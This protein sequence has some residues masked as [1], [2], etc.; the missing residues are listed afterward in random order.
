MKKFKTNIGDKEISFEIKNW[1][2]KANGEVL[3]TCGKT[4]VLVTAVMEEEDTDLGYFPLMVNY[5]ERF[6]ARGEILGSRYLRREGKPSNNAVLIA[7]LIDRTVRP[8]FPKGMKKEVQI[9]ATCL[10]WDGENDPDILGILGASFA[11][12]VS[13]IPWNGPIGAVRAVLK[14]GQVVINPVYEQR[15]EARLEI[16]LCGVKNSRE[17][18]VINM[19]EMEGEDA[20]EEQI[21]K[22]AQTALP[23]LQKICDLLEKA[24]K[25]AGREKIKLDIKKDENLAQQIDKFLQNKLEKTLFQNSNPNQE[26]LD[27]LKEVKKQTLEHIKG[28]YDQ[29]EAKQK[30]KQAGDIFE[31]KLGALI[32][33]KGMQGERV[34]G[35]KPNQVREIKCQAGPIP[36]THGSGL[37]SRGTTTSLSVITLGGPHEEKLIEGMEVSTKKRFLHH[38]N[39]PP[40]SVG[41]VKFLRAPGRREI[42]HGTLGEKTLSKII[43]DFDSFPY[44]IRIVSEILAS[45]GS[46]SMAAICSSSIALMEAGVPIKSPAAGIAIGMVKEKDRQ[47]LLVDIQ[48]PEDFHGAMDLKVAGTREGVNVIQMDV[49]ITGI[50][51]DTFEKALQEAKRAR[52]QILDSIEAEISEPK[53]SLSPLAPKVLKTVVP[54]DQIGKIIGSGGKT[55][56]HISE[57]TESEI[58]I[59][60]SGEVYV[61]AA[62]LANAQKAVNHINQIVKELEPGDT[63]VGEVSKTLPFGVIVDLVPGKDGLLHKSKYNEKLKQGDAVKV[64]VLRVDKTGKVDLALQKAQKEK[65]DGHSKKQF[66][67]KR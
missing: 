10:A 61:A 34:D 62:K 56:R 6:Y 46:T 4:Q 38:Y 12:S 64:K 26:K 45:N 24:Q 52:F 44:T 25:E 58:N 39:F 19:I 54:K 37:F 63:F 5:E 42:G 1:A 43:P 65:Q 31:E 55:I 60:E 40:Y 48:G 7:R 23:R 59:E 20:N 15:E 50:E 67:G 28:L 47:E 29:Q 22:A 9:I 30:V 16:T 21:L 18:T 14:D 27:A 35:R 36:H 53:P 17:K 13:N 33:K 11:L 41:E 32:H 66:R 3:V 2:K 8:L 49:K 57:E 51:L